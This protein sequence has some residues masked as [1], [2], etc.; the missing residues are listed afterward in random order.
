MGPEWGQGDVRVVYAG[1]MGR[2]GI[3]YRAGSEL[4]G[5]AGSM[6]RAAHL[7][8]EEV[9]VHDGAGVEEHEHLVAQGRAELGEDAPLGHLVG[10][11]VVR[12]RVVTLVWLNQLAS[13]TSIT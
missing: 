11:R 1:S 4:L 8:A 5:R 10:V 12:V 6:G 9:D 13:C 3:V 7:P 2:L